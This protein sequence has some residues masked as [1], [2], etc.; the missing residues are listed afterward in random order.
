MHMDLRTYRA[1]TLAEAVAKLKADLGHNALILHT[2]QIVE[3]YWLGLRRRQIVEIVAGRNLARRPAPPAAK[4]PTRSINKPALG[5]GASSPLSS[6]LPLN[7]LGTPTKITAPAATA[8]PLLQT[9]AA[10]NAVFLDLSD[11]MRQLRSMVGELSVQVQHQRVPHVPE[12]FAEHYLNLTAN[13]VSAEIAAEVIKAAHRAIRP[14]HLT[15]AEFVRDKL[16]EQLE[17]MLTI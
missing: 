17:R 12:E 7:A 4:A 1:P 5:S 13:Q 11:Q 14:E 8:Q 9:A 2:R 10:S 6:S 16:A 3:R 15:N